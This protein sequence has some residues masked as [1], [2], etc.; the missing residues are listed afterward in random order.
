MKKIVAGFLCLISVCVLAN[1]S[2][3]SNNLKK[4]NRQLYIM[5]ITSGVGRCIIVGSG[6]YTGVFADIGRKIPSVILFSAIVNRESVGLIRAAGEQISET[7]SL[8]VT[9][10]HLRMAILEGNCNFD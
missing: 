10:S 5:S 6:N 9:I 3:I 8:A 7:S 1:D 2:F 4:S